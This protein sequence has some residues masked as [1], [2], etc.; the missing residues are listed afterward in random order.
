KRAI[1]DSYTKEHSAE[2]QAQ[3]LIDLAFRLRGRIANLADIESVR[4]ITSHHTHA[5]IGTGSN[6]PQKMDPNASRE[7]L[8]QSLECIFAVGLEDGEWHHIR[9]YAPE[10]ARRPETVALWHKI[11]TVEDKDWTRRY[12]EP[13]PSK[14]AFGGR[15]EIKLKNGETIVDELAVANA[16]TNG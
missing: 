14:R 7:T 6:D 11:S 2:Y 10:R 5:V 1:L 12:L 16:H 3:A 9:S 13:D 15:V 4:I 8:E